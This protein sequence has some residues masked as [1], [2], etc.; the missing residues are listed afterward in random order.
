MSFMSGNP[1]IER[2]LFSEEQL[3]EVVAR[4]G[5][6]ITRDYEGKDVVLICVLRG[7]Y[8]FMAD[9]ARAIDLPIECDFMVVS[10]YGNLT[11]TS[12]TVRILKDLD[13][14]IEGRHVII[15]EDVVDS[16][17]TL[18][19]LVDVLK[20]RNPKSVE[21]AALFHK[22]RPGTI[23]CKY[24]GLECPDEFIVGYGLDY[25]EKYR[26]LPYVGVLAPSAIHD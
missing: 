12:G 14:S 3:Q 2:V 5:A 16:G 13:S 24:E 4:I 23:E 17:L 10:S 19:K 20:H 21:I 7:A 9:L 1:D 15:A 22:H 25:A 8:V 26:N 6:E 18:E 11:H